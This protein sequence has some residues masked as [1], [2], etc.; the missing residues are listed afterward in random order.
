MRKFPIALIV[1][2]GLLLT[3]PPA[4]LADRPPP[5]RFPHQHYLTTPAG[6]HQIGPNSCPNNATQGFYGFHWNVH[7]GTPSTN[8][9]SNENNP[10]AISGAPCPP[11]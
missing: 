1:S 6:T 7:A 5:T 2:G 10:V 3:A 4:A 9:F 8:A 11:A